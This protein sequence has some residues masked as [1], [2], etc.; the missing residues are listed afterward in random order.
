MEDKEEL[1][2]FC[3]FY[4]GDCLGYTRVIAKAA[5]TFMNVLEEYK[6]DRTAK[7]VFPEKLKGYD[8]FSEMLEFMTGLK[9]DKTCRERED[10]EVSCEVR[11]CCRS[12]G[13][14]ACYEC[15][16]FETCEKLKSL[17]GELHYVSSLK[18][19]KAIKKVGLKA[20]I[21]SGKRHCYWDESH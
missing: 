13:L 6:F 12:K 2:A 10:N 14:Y 11:K 8:R 3:G 21:T 4:C 9:C 15:D 5:R 17:H 20:W 7:S 18:N 16:D 19:L 1:L